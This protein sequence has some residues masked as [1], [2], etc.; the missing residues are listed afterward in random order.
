[1]AGV[2]DDYISAAPHELVAQHRPAHLETRIGIAHGYGH[3]RVELKFRTAC[4]QLAMFGPL[5]GAHTLVVER[6]VAALHW[7]LPDE[8][9]A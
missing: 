6:R 4:A 8:V 5:E 7:I 2:E 3:G 9:V 1:M